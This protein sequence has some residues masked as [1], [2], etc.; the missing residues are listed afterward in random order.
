MRHSSNISCKLAS[1]GLELCR[2]RVCSTFFIAC[3][4]PQP[5]VS[6]G[7]FSTR[8]YSSLLCRIAPHTYLSKQNLLVSPG[9]AS[10]QR[11]DGAQSL[12]PTGTVLHTAT[13]VACACPMPAVMGSSLQLLSATIK[14][15]LSR[16]C[17]GEEVT[18]TAPG[19]SLSAGAGG[20]WG[21]AQVS[22]AWG[23]GRKG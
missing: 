21:L 13:V 18:N 2:N 15:A 23:D 5:P 3:P 7:H 12:E 9:A 1:K 20:G 16:V 11:E 10:E 22:P 17:W 8:T 4:L 6:S 14:A 19:L